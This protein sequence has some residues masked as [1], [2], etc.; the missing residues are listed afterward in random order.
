MKTLRLS[1]VASA[2]AMSLGLS[3]TAFANTTSSSIKGYIT[4]PQNNPAAGTVVTIT[5]IPSGTS[6][7]TTVNNAGLFS[8]Q[9]L[10][11]GGPYK[12]TIDSDQFADQT[13]NNVFL[14]LG[15]SYQLDMSLK[16]DQVERIEVSGQIMTTDMAADSPSAS[17]D[18]SD[19][20]TA[21]TTTR[22]IKDVIRVDPRVHINES[23]TNNSVNC[24]GSNPRFNSLTVDGVRMN[25]NFGLNGNGYPTERLPFS[26]DAID[27]VTVELAPF[28]V[29]FGGF[30]ACNINAVT[31]S[32]GNEMHG[33]A[34][35]DYTSDNFQSR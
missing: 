27:Q 24:A 31:K 7:Q 20:Q 9:G 34:F 18:L 28:D 6:R 21:P 3:G 33:S 30:T 13:V 10:R 14:T 8:A 17:F 4:G 29:Q 5:H 25:D 2:M 1:L 15:E 19:M 23:N 16:P 35:F 32:G 12:V 26:F 22:D 11:V